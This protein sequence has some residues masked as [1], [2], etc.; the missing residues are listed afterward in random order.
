MNTT[1]PQRR[2]LRYFILGCCVLC[3]I[4]LWVLDK[5]LALWLH[6][7]TREL[8]PFFEALTNAVD[9]VY[10]TL[11]YSA[12]L[13]GVPIGFVAL[14]VLFLLGRFV[15]HA[16]NPGVFLLI[17]LVLLNSGVATNLL[18]IYFQRPRPDA[19][20]LHGMAGTGFWQATTRDY[21]FPSSHA[22]LYFS[23]LFPLAWQFP[24]YRW[25]LLVLPMLI[26]VGRLV[27]ELHFLGDVLASVG[28]V[29]V[30]TWLFSR[31]PFITPRTP[32]RLRRYQPTKTDE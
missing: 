26:T 20:L 28:L 25:P 18:K 12:D 23:L 32:F 10:M 5:P 21:S 2:E 15:L 27:L 30:L 29:G 7:Y 9:K 19:F 1:V 13:G 22:T 4:A 17:G 3:P 11:F 16:P 8:Q 6:E 14:F 31:L 24:R